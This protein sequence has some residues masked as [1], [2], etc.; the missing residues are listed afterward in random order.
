MPNPN[1]SQEL[2]DAQINDVKTHLENA[3]S[4]LSFLVNLTPRER[5][6]LFKMGPKSVSFVEFALDVA[7]NHPSIVPSSFSVAEF[8]KDVKLTKSLQDINMLSKPLSEGISDTYLLAGSE[9]MKQANFIYE[10]VKIAAKH[11]SAMDQ[12]RVELKRRYEKTKTK[13]T[14]G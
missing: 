11:D 10:Q 14:E 6:K 7:K 13:S 5:K 9:A 1:L 8:E 4:I 3:K 12:L 2:T